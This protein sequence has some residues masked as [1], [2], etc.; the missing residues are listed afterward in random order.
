[1]EQVQAHVDDAV[2]KGATAMT[3]GARA[4]GLPPPHDR[5]NFFE[6]TI[7]AGATIDMRV[8]REETFG[9]AVPLFRCVSARRR[10]LGFR[11]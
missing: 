4:W 5:G 6:P 9:P 10:A 2:A 3:G 8:F 11:V 1:M 7:L